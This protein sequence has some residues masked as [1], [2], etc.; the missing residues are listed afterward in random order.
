M[1]GKYSFFSGSFFPLQPLKQ[2]KATHDSMHPASRTCMWTRRCL[3]SCTQM[4]WADEG[5]LAEGESLHLPCTDLTT[6]KT[7]FAL[8]LPNESSHIPM[9]YINPACLSPNYAFYSLKS[10]FKKVWCDSTSTCQL[11][12]QPTRPHLFTL[13]I[14][15]ISSLNTQSHSRFLMFLP[16][17]NPQ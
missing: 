11:N 17:S 14:R 1:T 6:G 8:K 5:M 13:V 10:N 16:L 12:S 2:T 9:G 7:R 3:L 4:C 15:K